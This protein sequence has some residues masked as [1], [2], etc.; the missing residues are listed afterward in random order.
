MADQFIMMCIREKVQ[1][2]L[3]D[4][5]DPRPVSPARPIPVFSIGTDV[6]GSADYKAYAA[7]LEDWENRMVEYES[8]LESWHLK[9]NQLLEQFSHDLA[10]QHGMIGHPKQEILYQMALKHAHYH[11]KGL[12]SVITWYEEFLILVK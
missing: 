2:G 1:A 6:P 3:Y 4:L 9:Q 7:A 8:M 11:T 12:P 10:V 5:S